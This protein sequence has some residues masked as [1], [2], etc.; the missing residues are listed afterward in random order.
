MLV[1]LGMCVEYGDAYC[2]EYQQNQGRNGLSIE[3]RRMYA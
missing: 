2:G 1:L 3:M